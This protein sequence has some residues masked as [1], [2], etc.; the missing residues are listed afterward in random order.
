[1]IIR[2]L[3]WAFGRSIC[4]ALY[5]TC[6]LA[7]QEP[8][9]TD[10]IFSPAGQS[11]VAC[12]Q[13]GLQIYSWPDLKLQKRVEVVATN[14]HAVRFS[15][16][17]KRLAVGGGNPAEEG[18]V[19]IFSWP[20]CVSLD[21]FIGH[22]D[23]VL[24]VQ[25]IGP[26]RIVSVSLDRQI[27]LWNLAKGEREATL[28]GHSRGV[29]SLGI[30]PG[31]QWVTAGHDRSVR[32]WDGPTGKLTRT[33]NQHTGD[34]HALAICPVVN[35]QPMVATAAEDRSIRFWQPTIG[36]MMRYIRLDSTPLDIAWLDG[37]HLVAACSDGQLRLVNTDQVKLLGVE[38]AIDGWAYAVACH[39]ESGAI[40]VAGSGGQLKSMTL[41]VGK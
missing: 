10:I 27:I 20:E 28:R 2:H 26:E 41:P 13:R 4:L 38:P 37:S 16:D 34:V 9:I 39:P 24:A 23:S 7:G 15:P 25:W 21:T 11:V 8:P 31:D 1:M 40:V 19:E 5:G 29:S 35:N 18:M 3:A 12:S 36:R 14:L 17:G 6:L 22:D 32:V 30:L 33:L